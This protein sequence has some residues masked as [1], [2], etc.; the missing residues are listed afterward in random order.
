MSGRPMT[1][2]V[3]QV[4]LQALIHLQLCL[5]V[6]LVEYQ[7]A[8]PHILRCRGV[9]AGSVVCEEGMAGVAVHAKLVGFPVLV[10]FFLQAGGMGW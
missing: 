10:E 2:R 8:M 9:I 4:Q 5:E 7:D 6:L 3:S 1:P